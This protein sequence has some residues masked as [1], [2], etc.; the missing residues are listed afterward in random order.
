MTDRRVCEAWP[1]P[2]LNRVSPSHFAIET[3]AVSDIVA[4]CGK[5]SALQED[6][7]TGYVP[8]YK[9]LL[10]DNAIIILQYISYV[11]YDA[12]QDGAVETLLINR[13]RITV[14]KGQCP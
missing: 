9:E 5:Y 1:M 6:A 3:M 4:A 14:L 11:R 12:L 10:E 13:H 2:T 7:Q 8:T